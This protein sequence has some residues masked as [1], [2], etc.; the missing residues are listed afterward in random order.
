L[1]HLKSASGA[2][3]AVVVAGLVPALQPPRELEQADGWMPWTSHGM[4]R[5]KAS[6]DF[7]CRGSLSCRN[8]ASAKYA[9]PRSVSF[10]MGY[11]LPPVGLARWAGMTPT[12]DQFDE[13][14]K[15]L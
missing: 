5:Q 8:F 14:A 7:E 2:T 4:A 15:S 12:T 9:V 6:A 10:Q 3:F 1:L 13:I 11:W